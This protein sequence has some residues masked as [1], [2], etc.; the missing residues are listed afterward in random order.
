MQAN[1]PWLIRTMDDPHST[2][3][4]IAHKALTANPAFADTLFD[5]TAPLT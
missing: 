4:Y 1:A 5:H 3:R 2:I